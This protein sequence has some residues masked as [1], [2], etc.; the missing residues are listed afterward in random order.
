MADAN[1]GEVALVHPNPLE[2]ATHSLFDRQPIVTSNPW[3][4]EMRNPCQ[5][6]L[7]RLFG[8]ACCWA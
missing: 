1:V 6:K 5:A 8:T 4:V 7:P 3:L 2:M